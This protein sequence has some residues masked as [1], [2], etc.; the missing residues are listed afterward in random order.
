MLLY[1]L[2][3]LAL[4][5]AAF[6]GTPISK[7]E[8]S[9]AIQRISASQHADGSFGS[10]VDTY[11]AVR[12]LELLGAAIPNSAAL[13]AAVTA[14]PSNEPELAVF[15]YLSSVVAKC[16]PAAFPESSVKE[17][18]NSQDV[19]KIR[20]ASLAV[21]S[22]KSKAKSLPLSATIKTLVSLQELD[23]SYRASASSES[24]SAYLAALA[25]QSISALNSVTADST[26]VA[27]V[28]EKLSNLFS[29]GSWPGAALEPNFG[30]DAPVNAVEAGAEVAR[31]LFAAARASGS[32]K[33]LSDS[34]WASIFDRLLSLRSLSSPRDIFGTLEALNE[35]RLATSEG[36]LPQ[37]VLVSPLDSQITAGKTL[38]VR[39]TDALD[40]VVSGAT[41]ISK[42]TSLTFSQSDKGISTASASSVDSTLASTDSTVVTIDVKASIES[43]LSPTCSLQLR[44]ARQP[45][46]GQISIAVTGPNSMST[47][48]VCR[49]F[50]FTFLTWFWFRL[51]WN[52][53]Y[54][55]SISINVLNSLQ[56]SVSSADRPTVVRIQLDR[57]GFNTAYFF[58]QWASA[59]ADAATVKLNFGSGEVLEQLSGP[60]RYRLSVLV[61][62]R[63]WTKPLQWNVAELD[64]DVPAPQSNYIRAQQSQREELDQELRVQPTLFHTFQSTGSR[65]SSFIALLITAAMVVPVLALLKFTAPWVMAFSLP[66]SGESVWAIAFLGSLTGMI[67]IY[68][69]YW[70]SLNIFQV[71]PTVAIAGLF[72]LFCG[73]KA[74]SRHHQRLNAGSSD[75][76]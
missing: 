2:G 72:C 59:S 32:S 25:V 12:S 53:E 37:L 20:I 18:L 48:S 42:K 49:F 23:G 30:L 35:A 54:S 39:V 15:Q 61:G 41:V 56:I 71:A 27:T 34:Q 73:H 57:E 66:R 24:S 36:A 13:C 16:S 17:L 28:V 58:A 5:S 74:L 67:G 3:L 22:A 51:A 55:N 1:L 31:A 65:P 60:G 38:Q 6:S 47:K 50:K 62:D 9:G 46:A 52:K 68:F 19:E 21:Q 14:A 43:S 8:Q 7:S 45:E 33:F 70:T 10:L 63:R 44:S 75:S 76:K 69:V 64:I 29:L 11:F 26:S 4:A 40:N